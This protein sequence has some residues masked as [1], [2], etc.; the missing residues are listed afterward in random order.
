M[1]R[2]PLCAL[3]LAL[4]TI[5]AFAKPFGIGRSF[6]FAGLSIKQTLKDERLVLKSVPTPHPDFDTYVVTATPHDGVC[7]IQ[8]LSPVMYED[9]YGQKAR[10]LFDRVRRQLGSVYGEGTPTASLNRRSPYKEDRRWTAA[11]QH[12]D[13]SYQASW[14]G[15]FQENVRSIVLSVRAHGM[16]STF[17]EI[18]YQFDNIE[19]CK[20]TINDD[21]AGTL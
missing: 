11:L 21:A 20:A 9:A 19:S 18:D 17:V 4:T 8:A 12:G 10:Q 16:V 1:P 6:P 13:R 5:P 15:A 14:T 7:A 2:L 3:L